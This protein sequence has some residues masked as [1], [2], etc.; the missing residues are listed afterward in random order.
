MNSVTA[1]SDAATALPGSTV[2]VSTTPSVGAL[3]D[4]FDRLVWSVDSVACASVT[5]ARALASS[6]MRTLQR[7]AAGVQ[8]GL[9]RHLAARQARHFLEAAPRPALASFTVADGLRHL[10][11]RGGERGARAHDLVAQLGGVELDQHLAL[12]DAVVDVDVDLSTVP[13]SSLPMLIERVG[14]SV[15]LAVT[16]SVRSPRATVCVV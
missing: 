9:G 4:A 10:G 16:V 2:R 15:P 8:L 7:G 11:V 5:L 1:C 3:I 13:D 12:L 14:C 6:A